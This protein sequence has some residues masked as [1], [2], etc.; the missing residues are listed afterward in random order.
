MA[1]AAARTQEQIRRKTLRIVLVKW[2]IAI[3]LGARA[4]LMMRRLEAARVRTRMFNHPY[5]TGARET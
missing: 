3:A 2:R 1:A 5:S 4:Q